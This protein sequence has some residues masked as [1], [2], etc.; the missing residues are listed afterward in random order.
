M[1]NSK[2]NDES[3][4][5]EN[6]NTDAHNLDYYLRV[7]TQNFR[8]KMKKQYPELTTRELYV[9]SFIRLNY[10]IKETAKHLNLSSRTIEAHRSNIRHKVGLQKGE[11]LEGFI[12]AIEI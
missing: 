7:E 2:M 3:Y 6:L 4:N 12:I 10:D 8:T 5:N 1:Q 11:N 9:C